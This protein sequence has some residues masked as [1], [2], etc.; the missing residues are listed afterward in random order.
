LYEAFNNLLTNNSYELIIPVVI[1][2]IAITWF[3][4]L[5]TTD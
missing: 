4:I 1:Q 2:C 5:E 3:S